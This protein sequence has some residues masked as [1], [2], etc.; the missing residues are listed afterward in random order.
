MKVTP[1]LPNWIRHAD[2]PGYVAAHELCE[3]EARL[4]GTESLYGDWGA[5]VLLLAKD[6]GPT[7]IMLDRIVCGDSRPYRHEPNMLTNRRLR[8]L[9]GPIVG[10]GLLY[11]SALG[12]LLRDDGQVSGA[13]PN[14]GEAINYGKEVTRFAVERM[15][16]L[17]W[18]MCLGQE[19]WE[20]AAAAQEV[21]GDWK[22][23]RDSGRPLGLLVAAYHPAA[24]VSQE[25]MAGPWE[26]LARLA[27]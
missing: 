20:V 23:H 26:A 19:A 14:R 6:F 15:S 9:A 1:P 17:R 7:Q 8:R 11:G 22:T 12:N 21:D 10:S 25:R 4:Y 13:L 16:A 2:V 18:I 5:T 24:R 27:G 3:G